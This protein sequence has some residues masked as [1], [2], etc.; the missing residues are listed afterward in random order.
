[1]KKLSLIIFV[2]I[3][4]HN[5]V[6]S[7]SCLPEGIEFATQSQ[8][9]SF[10]I[11][12]PGCTEIEGDVMIS[13]DSITNLFGLSQLTDIYGDLEFSG[14][15]LLVNF[16]GL[17]NLDSI[18]GSL[19]VNFNYQ[20]K[21]F[22]GLDHLRIINGELQIGYHWTVSNPVLESLVGLEGLRAIGDDLYISLNPILTD[23]IPLDSLVSIGGDLTIRNNGNLSDILFH[24]PLSQ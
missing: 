23:L 20:L 4:C 5:A 10:P 7:Q 21:N 11:N 1:M 8:I 15:D 12:H 3:Y 17:S 16:S 13:G 2:L 22:S 24:R 6:S 19:I 14:N 9:D 18:G